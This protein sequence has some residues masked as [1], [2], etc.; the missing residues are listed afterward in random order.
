VQPVLHYYSI[1][2]GVVAFSSTRYG[3][4]SE[5][6][7]AAFNVN[8]YCGDQLA[9]I[10]ENRRLL[11]KVLDIDESHLV[12]P[13]QTHNTEVR[14]VDSDLLSLSSEERLRQLEG[15]DAVVTDLKGVCIAVSTADC[16]PV[17]LYD[18]AHHAVAAIHAGWRGTVAR[19]VEKT[20]AT[21]QRV[22]QTNPDQLK[23]V[24][25][26]GICLKNFEVGD[27]VYAEFEQNGFPMNEIA[28]QFPTT[29]EVQ[30]EIVNGKLSNSKLFWHID[31]PACNRLQLVHVG[32]KNENIHMSNICTYDHV[33][34]FFS[35]RR[36]GINSG[37]ILTGIMLNS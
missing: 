1:A 22:Y 3:G 6:N 13:H 26:P 14:V 30:S 23:A 21:M 33:D 34:T 2:D 19:I 31:L 15:V 32:V 20:V 29:N 35:A 36:L 18:E 17:L 9:H 4:I 5:G 24:I 11:C 27:E 25:G 37:R 12:Y 16:I 10:V 28:Q 8:H 7:Y